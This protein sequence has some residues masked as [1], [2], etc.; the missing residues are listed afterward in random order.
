MKTS[1]TLL[2]SVLVGFVSAVQA[3]GPTPTAT[4][5]AASLQR[6]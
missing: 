2:V 6:K 1:W 4:E 5:V 3:Q